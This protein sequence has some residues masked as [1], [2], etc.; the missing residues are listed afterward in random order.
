MER[1]EGHC[2][3]LAQVLKY[4]FLSTDPEGYSHPM[5]IRFFPDTPHGQDRE[6]ISRWMD[7][8]T[9]ASSRNQTRGQLV[10]ALAFAAKVKLPCQYEGEFG[11]NFTTVT[12]KLWETMPTA[13]HVIVDTEED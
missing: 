6:A 8:K 2:A 13:D 12:R 4:L 7:C 11:H 1:S 10:R 3:D 9:W 5:W